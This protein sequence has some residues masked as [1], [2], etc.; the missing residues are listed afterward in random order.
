MGRPTAG[1]PFLRP[2]VADCFLGANCH[3]GRGGGVAFGKLNLVYRT[4][5]SE[6]R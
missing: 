6:V 1:K 4:R 5:L 2:F 3:A